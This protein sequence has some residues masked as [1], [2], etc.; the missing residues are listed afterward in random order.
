MAIP[1]QVTTLMIQKI[2]GVKGAGEVSLR[3]PT[4]NARLAP[5]QHID[6]WAGH[7]SL[8]LWYE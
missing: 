7:L 4:R 6:P 2:E 5:S 1:W 8:H 3:S